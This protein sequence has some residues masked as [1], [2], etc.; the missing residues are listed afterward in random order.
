MCA[1]FVGN[2]LH[3]LEG[4]IMITLNH[5]FKSVVF[6]LFVETKLFLGTAL[7]PLPL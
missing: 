7:S 5:C 1:H 3:L 2:V 4:T 6:F